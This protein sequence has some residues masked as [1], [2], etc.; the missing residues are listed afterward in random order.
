MSLIVFVFVDTRGR[1]HSIME[2][3]K[4]NYLKYWNIFKNMVTNYMKH[5]LFYHLFTDLN[6]TEGDIMEV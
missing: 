2:I 3:N 4:G 5:D 1:E 6:L